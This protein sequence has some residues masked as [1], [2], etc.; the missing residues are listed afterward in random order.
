MIKRYVLDNC[1]GYQSLDEYKNG[2]YILFTDH[3]AEN[4]RLRESS[5]RIMVLAIKHC[6]RTHH[7][8][9]EVLKLTEALEVKDEV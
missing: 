3:E 2:N 8:Y 1:C 5:E 7:D 9:Q 6:P 4:K